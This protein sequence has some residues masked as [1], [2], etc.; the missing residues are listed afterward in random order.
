M[1]EKQLYFFS[2]YWYTIYKFTRRMNMDD[3]RLDN[4]IEN[5]MIDN[6]STKIPAAFEIDDFA[7]IKQKENTKDE[8]A[9]EKKEDLPDSK[10]DP[11]DKNPADSI[12]EKEKTDIQPKTDEPIFPALPLPKPA[13]D[14]KNNISIFAFSQQGQSHL[15]NM[16][17]CQDRC[18]FRIVGKS[19]IL[20]AVADGVG[21]C[22]LSDYGAD[23]AVQSSL[24]FL[25]IQLEPLV[26]Q[27]D[28]L[29][30]SKMMGKMLRETMQYAYENVEK[31]A[32]QLQQ[33]VYSLQSTLTIAV[34][35]GKTL[36]FAHAGDD[37]IVALDKN[38]RYAMVTSRHKAAEA[39]SVFPLQSKPTWQFGKVDNTVAFIMATDG[40]LDAFVRPESENNRVYY[41]FVEPIFNSTISNIEETKSVCEDWFEYMAGDTY[42]SI[43]TDDLTLIGVV[44]QS[45]IKTAVSPVFDAQEWNRKTKEYEARRM[46]ALYP[47]KNPMQR[48]KTGSKKGFTTSSANYTQHK[49]KSLKAALPANK[50]SISMENAENM[51]QFKGAL[52]KGTFEFCDAAKIGSAIAINWLGGGL[53]QLGGQMSKRSEEA[54]RK[55]QLDKQNT[56][57]HD[58]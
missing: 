17:P 11:Y 44:N 27:P 54:M 29:L 1:S 41:P 22:A 18:A 24:N 14:Y 21:S 5:M 36:Y 57:N 33:L 26:K 37:G 4:H 49:Q 7:D 48:S 3:N 35:D 47:P 8:P 31:K 50:R 23:E 42:R 16:Q 56:A 6:N 20:A 15:G 39:S 10:T 52:K 51:K 34:Y 28:F 55:R 2:F 9:D 58:S 13:Y 19:L 32:D 12:S 46:A 30:D 53:S 25:E 43:V 45:D 38:G 40:V